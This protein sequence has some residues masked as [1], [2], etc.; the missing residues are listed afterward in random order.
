M[1]VVLQASNRRMN[2]R[3]MFNLFGK[4]ALLALVPGWSRTFAGQVGTSRQTM[5]CSEYS[6]NGEF[7]RA[8]YGEGPNKVQVG[9]KGERTKTGVV[10]ELVFTQGSDLLLRLL[11]GIDRRSDEQ[12]FG[13]LDFTASGQDM[14]KY[15]IDLD[16]T[17]VTLDEVGVPNGLAKVTVVYRD[18]RVK[19][20]LDTKSDAP[21]G[22]DDAPRFMD[23]LPEATINRIEPLA[24]PLEA[25]SFRLEQSVKEDRRRLRASQSSAANKKPVVCDALCVGGAAALAQ[26]ICLGTGGLGCVI[27]WGLCSAAASVCLD[28]GCSK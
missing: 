28:K 18:R 11:S 21:L 4:G 23:V 20:S 7:N 1:T 9:L 27:S 8:W 5:I 17:K 19:G 13:H 3:G 25:L 12:S 24:P 2:R 16:A 15:T 14:S 6:A 26:L 10:A 22:L